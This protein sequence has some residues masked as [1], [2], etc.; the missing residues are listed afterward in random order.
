MP[1]CF[2]DQKFTVNDSIVE[3]SFKKRENEL[4]LNNKKNKLPWWARMLIDLG[5]QI[6]LDIFTAG[7]GAAATK[8]IDILVTSIVDTTIDMSEDDSISDTLTDVAFDLIP[9]VQKSVLRSFKYFGSE[10]AKVL[11]NIRLLK[12]ASKKYV[13]RK[14][15]RTISKKLSR[16]LIKLGSGEVIFNDSKLDKKIVRRA[17]RSIEEK[18]TDLLEK[19]AKIKFVEKFSESKTKYELYKSKIGLFNQNLKVANKIIGYVNNPLYTIKELTKNITGKY[20]TKSTEYLSKKLGFKQIEK[21]N[22]RSINKFISDKY[23]NLKKRIQKLFGKKVKKD[24]MSIP[25]YS[26]WI[27]YIKIYNS[28]FGTNLF[29]VLVVFKPEETNN[30]KP[31][32]LFAKQLN[33]IQAFLISQ[34]KGKFYIDNFSYGWEVG[35]LFRK[36]KAGG[37]GTQSLIPLVGS[38]FPKLLTT[39]SSVSRLMK[40]IKNAGSMFSNWNNE[41]LTTKNIKN[42]VASGFLSNLKGRSA[43]IKNFTNAAINKD[44]KYFVRS[45]VNN[46]KRSIKKHKKHKK[47]NF[48]Q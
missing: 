7:V 16:D 40:T 11:R 39:Y 32:L 37:F 35:R 43:L 14:I 20:W 1:L 13:S 25:V 19:K 34:S 42:Y 45:A 23:N 46:I 12:T 22:F 9:L 30:K 4:K 15:E 44:G 31:V 38:M 47:L 18:Y 26:K 48:L 27:E 3:L 17:Y 10:T 29:N 28:E 6:I 5:V 33:K 2:T 24:R 41:T 8:F 21:W 36:A